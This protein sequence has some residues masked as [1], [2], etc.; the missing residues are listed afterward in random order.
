MRKGFSLIELLVVILI[1]SLVYF[2]GFEEFELGTSKPKPLTPM[3]LKTQI[4]KSKLSEEQVTLMC[5]DKCRTCYLR[6]DISSPFQPYNNAID[7]QDIKAYT[8]DENDALVDIEYGRYNDKKICLLMD[9]YKNGSS[10]Q[11]ILEHKENAYFLP[12][13]FADPM[14]FDSPEDAKEYWVNKGRSLSDSGAFY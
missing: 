7:L 1:I 4:L 2:L 9:F 12:S 5:L 13:F 8:V 6:S 14:R 11:I 10:T 3:N